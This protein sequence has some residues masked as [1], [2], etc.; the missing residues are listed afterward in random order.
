MI[1]PYLDVLG[2]LA[3]TGVGGYLTHVLRRLDRKIEQVEK[4]EVALFGD[5]DLGFPGL[6]PLVTDG[7]TEGD[8]Q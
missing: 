3:V 2:P 8:R 7:G 5:D 4:H 1:V 6:V